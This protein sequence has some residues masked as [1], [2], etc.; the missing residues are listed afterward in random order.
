MPKDIPKDRQEDRRIDRQMDRRTQIQTQRQTRRRTQRQVET[1]T[2][3]KRNEEAEGYCNCMWRT[4]HFLV[5]VFVLLLLRCLSWRLCNM[6]ALQCFCF[7]KNEGNCDRCI[8]LSSASSSS[9][10]SSSYCRRQRHLSSA[11]SSTSFS[12]SLSPCPPPLFLFATLCAAAIY[13]CLG[14]LLFCHL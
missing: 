10:P 12:L 7:P 3:R 11:F 5:S 13:H 8:L 2:N 14:K 1:E 9:F 6:A 4:S